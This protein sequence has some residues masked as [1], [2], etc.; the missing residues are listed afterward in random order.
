MAL[1]LHASIAAAGLPEPILGAD[2]RAQRVKTFK[3]TKLCTF[4]ENG[5]CTRGEDCYFAHNTDEMRKKPVFMKT[6]LCKEFIEMGSCN[7][8]VRCNFAHGRSELR[9]KARAGTAKM[10]A[11]ERDAPRAVITSQEKVDEDEGEGSFVW[12][13]LCLS[14][15][16]P[17]GKA[18]ANRASTAKCRTRQNMPIE[19]KSH[20]EQGSR[21]MQNM[22]VC[23]PAAFHAVMASQIDTIFHEAPLRRTVPA[24]SH[25]EQ[26]E[27]D[28]VGVVKNDGEGRKLCLWDPGEVSPQQVHSPQH[29]P[30]VKNTFIHLQEDEN[31]APALRKSSSLPFLQEIHCDGSDELQPW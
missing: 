8:G 1:T 21:A 30:T 4:F 10:L 15:S 28:G 9:G 31:P 17:K 19:G 29:Q 16:E 2:N 26:D 11:G 23:D 27:D 20:A 24:Q 25:D 22:P 12:D 6:R 5:T 14:G 7:N 3:K 13:P 18:R